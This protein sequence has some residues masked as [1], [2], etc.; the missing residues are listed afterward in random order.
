ALALVGWTQ[1]REREVSIHYLHLGA[2]VAGGALVAAERLWIGAGVLPRAMGIRAR[3][4]ATEARLWNGAGDVFALGQFRAPLKKGSRVHLL[5]SMRL[6]VE[7]T[8]PS[9]LY[10][11]TTTTIR[12]GDVR[13]LLAASVGV[14]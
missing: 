14:L 12:R 11:G 4:G 13:G 7:I 5:A 6:G 9:I 10:R 2:G 3:E 8:L 1:T